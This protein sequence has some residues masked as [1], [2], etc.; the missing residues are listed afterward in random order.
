VFFFGVSFNFVEV[1]DLFI[2][3]FE[4]SELIFARTMRNFEDIG[5]FD[6]FR[7]DSKL[8]LFFLDLRL[9]FELPNFLREVHK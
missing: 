7:L 9:I 1:D 5:V 2:V 8:E 3:E 6:I 4:L